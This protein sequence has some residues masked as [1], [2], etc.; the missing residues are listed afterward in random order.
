M[1]NGTGGSTATA[2]AAT[3]TTQINTVE[4]YKSV[5]D[6]NKTIISMSS[7]VLAALIAY[8]I[9]QNVEFRLFNYVSVA[10]L[11][12][13]ILLSIFGFGQAIRTVK[14]GVS[15][16]G[17]I[18]LTNFGAIFL[19]A[20]ILANLFIK[21]DIKTIDEILKSVEKSTITLDKK[22]LPQNCKSIELKDDDYILQYKGDTTNSVVTYSIKKQTIVSIK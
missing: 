4:A 1:S 22:L 21:D 3:T 12:I 14:D 11:V 20:G 18:A 8:L 2:A 7:A 5:I 15:R 13:S 19:M 16:T 17:T 10:L 6:F 9:Y